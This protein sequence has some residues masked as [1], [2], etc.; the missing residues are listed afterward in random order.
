MI[1]HRCKLCN[2]SWMCRAVTEEDCRLDE[3]VEKMEKNESDIAKAKRLSG[4]PKVE[5]GNKLFYIPS[6]NPWAN[7]VVNEGI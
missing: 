5:V 7:G 4:L 1:D 3:F 2:F 6:P